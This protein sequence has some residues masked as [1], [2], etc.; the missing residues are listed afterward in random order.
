[1]NHWNRFRN[2]LE[3]I[4]RVTGGRDALPLAIPGSAVRT[5][6]GLIVSATP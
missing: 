3:R 5:C 4:I 1:M 2:F 6:S